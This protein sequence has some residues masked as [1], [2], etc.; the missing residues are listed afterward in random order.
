[1]FSLMTRHRHPDGKFPIVGGDQSSGGF[2]IGVQGVQ[3]QNL[4]STS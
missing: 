3:Y 1:M 2:C 4:A